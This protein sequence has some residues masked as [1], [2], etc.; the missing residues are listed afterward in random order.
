MGG[1]GGLPG[2]F[3]GERGGGKTEPEDISGARPRLWDQEPEQGLSP[4]GLP[5]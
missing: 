1:R 2:Q 4:R 3:V 5:S